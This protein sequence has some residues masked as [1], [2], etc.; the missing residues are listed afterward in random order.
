MRDTSCAT[1]QER[2][3]FVY[4]M[5]LQ[6]KTTDA[7]GTKQGFVPCKGKCINVHSIHVNGKLSGCLGC[8]HKQQQI[9]FLTEIS[10]FLQ[11]NHGAEHIGSVSNDYG[12]GVGA[13]KLR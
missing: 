13:K 4:H 1:G 7:L 11:G 3:D 12:P 6:N 9:V 8:V 2:R 5:F 10:Y